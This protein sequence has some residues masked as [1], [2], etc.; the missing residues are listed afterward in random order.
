MRGEGG[1]TRVEVLFAG[2]GRRADSGGARAGRERKEGSG[3]DSSAV[4]DNR[5]KRRVKER[6]E[7][8]G[9]SRAYV[10]LCPFHNSASAATREVPWE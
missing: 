7:K 9:Q 4:D 6:K 1:P 5:G 2:K 10:N 8:K 3:G